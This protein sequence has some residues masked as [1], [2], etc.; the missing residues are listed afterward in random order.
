MQDT[1]A[2]ALKTCNFSNIGPLR[3]E[4]GHVDPKVR[5]LVSAYRT[6]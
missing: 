6:S 1:R 2:G 4:F 5:H 3:G